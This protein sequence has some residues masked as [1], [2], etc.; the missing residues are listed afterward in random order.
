MLLTHAHNR[1]TKIDCAS[2][3]LTH[4]QQHFCCVIDIFC[5]LIACCLVIYCTEDFCAI[6]LIDQLF[7]LRQEGCWEVN[8]KKTK[9]TEGKFEL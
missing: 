6:V 8:W 9:K 4:H 1:H 7:Q 5:H 3:A 2:I